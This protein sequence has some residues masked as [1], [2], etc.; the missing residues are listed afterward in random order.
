MKHLKKF[1]NFE[2]IDEGIDFGNVR[3]NVNK[4]FTGH[5]GSEEKNTAKQRILDDIDVAIARLVD[6]GMPI[7]IAE[8]RKEDIIKQ[9][10]EDNW[11]GK[12]SIRNSRASGKTFVVY[13]EGRTG[14]HA[15]GASAAGSVKGNL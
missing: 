8:K 5:S 3:G 9:A 14:L 1:D 12:I 10:A 15:L 7:D 13:D 4:F 6:D 2:N 11:K